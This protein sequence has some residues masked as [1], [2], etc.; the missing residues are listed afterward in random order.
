M[1]GAGYKAI[2]ISCRLGGACDCPFIFQ[3]DGDGDADGDVHLDEDDDGDD[4]DDEDDED[5]TDGSA[6]MCAARTT[7]RVRSQPGSLTV[8]VLCL[9]YPFITFFIF[10]L[11]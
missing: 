10:S 1:L 2:I 4:G 8:C 9:Q 7:Q 6:L 11:F 5:C 3:D